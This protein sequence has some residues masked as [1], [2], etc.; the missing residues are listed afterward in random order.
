MATKTNL[1]GGDQ[2]RLGIEYM[3]IEDLIP[4]APDADSGIP[5]SIEQ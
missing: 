2:P 1:R 5:M 4:I 3:L